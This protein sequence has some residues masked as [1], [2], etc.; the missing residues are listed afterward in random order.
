MVNHIFFT[1]NNIKNIMSTVVWIIVFLL[2]LWHV[3][4]NDANVIL[5][6]V[7]GSGEQVISSVVGLGKQ[8]VNDVVDNGVELGKQVMNYIAILL[9]MIDKRSVSGK[10]VI[11]DVVG[12][13]KQVVNDVV[14]SGKQ[15]I[16]SGVESGKQVVNDVVDNTVTYDEIPF[17]EAPKNNV[18]RNNLDEIRS[19]YGMYFPMD[20]AEAPVMPSKYLFDEKRSYVGCYMDDGDIMPINLGILNNRECADQSSDLGYNSYGMKYGDSYTFGKAQCRVGNDKNFAR[21]GESLNCELHGDTIVGGIDNI[22]IYQRTTV[23]IY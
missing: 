23:P 21:Q 12:S 15:V 3:K 19:D 14:G 10:Q 20:E 7:V 6:D 2:L 16:S 4:K 18:N 17:T 5:N 9:L 22:A 8:V 1:Y 13:G 11:N